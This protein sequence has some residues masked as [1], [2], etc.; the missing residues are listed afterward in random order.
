[1]FTIFFSTVLL[2]VASSGMS[3]SDINPEIFHKIDSI[4]AKTKERSEIDCIINDLKKRKIVEQFYNP[5]LIHNTTMLKIKVTPFLEASEIVCANDAI[6]T[7]DS[8]SQLSVKEKVCVAIGVAFVA[9][10]IVYCIV[11]KARQLNTLF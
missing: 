7:Q 5:E 2:A 10:V 9:A 8:E 11:K 1:M 3:T 6:P 4:L